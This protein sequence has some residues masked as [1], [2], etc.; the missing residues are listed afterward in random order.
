MD[1]AI[2]HVLTAAGIKMAVFW[3]VPPYSK[4]QAD[5]YCLHHQVSSSSY[6]ISYNSEFHVSVAFLRRV[7]TQNVF[8]QEIL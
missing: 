4:V 1:L 6:F 5:A 7:G 2:F 3:V 8:Y